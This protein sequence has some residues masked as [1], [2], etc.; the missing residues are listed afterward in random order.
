MKRATLPEW[1]VGITPP[2]LNFVVVPTVT[3][4]P[5]P[6]TFW[7]PCSH[8]HIP[9]VPHTNLGMDT[10]TTTTF[11]AITTTIPAVRGA[12]SRGP[13]QL[14]GRLTPCISVVFTIHGRHSVSHCC[15]RNC[16]RLFGSL[17][18]YK[19]YKYRPLCAVRWCGP[20]TCT[21]G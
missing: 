14:Q 7:G 2:L 1:C 4:P 6:L 19:R 20:Y 5:K 12:H 8:F 16:T 9:A 15:R 13:L 3:M 17:L 21:R 10:I 18:P 11:G